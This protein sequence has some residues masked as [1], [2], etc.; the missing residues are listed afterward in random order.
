[1]ILN[2]GFNLIFNDLLIEEVLNEAVPV[3]IEPAEP[4][5]LHD[6]R[7]IASD[8]LDIR[9]EYE[10]SACLVYKDTLTRVAAKVLIFRQTEAGPEVLMRFWRSLVELPGGGFD[11]NKDNY[12]IENTI[13]REVYEEL[14]IEL[15]NIK[16]TK[17]NYCEFADRPWVQK[18]VAK[19]EDRW[20]A[21]YTYVYTA[22]YAGTGS[23][24]L[25]EELGRYKWY[26]VSDILE[27]KDTKKL[28]IYKDA[29]KDSGYANKL[30]EAIDESITLTEERQLGLVSYCVHDISEGG[31]KV[32]TALS[33]L[34]LILEAEK[35][36]TSIDSDKT[37]YVSTSRD[38]TGHLG[39][40]WSC[41]IV[42]DGTKVTNKYK[43]A[44]INHNGQIYFNDM[45]TSKHLSLN[46]IYE[47]TAIGLSKQANL[48]RKMSAK[49]FKRRE[50]ATYDPNN[51]LKFY[52]VDLGGNSFFTII[53][54]KTFDI[55]HDIML[56]YNEMPAVQD[57]KGAAEKYKGR[58]NVEVKKYEVNV[59]GSGRRYNTIA[60]ISSLPSR[61]QDYDF[62][63]TESYKYNV[64]NSGLFIN[65]SSLSRFKNQ[66]LEKYGIDITSNEFFR[67]V[68]GKEYSDEAEERIFPRES[69]V[70]YI[71]VSGCIKLILVSI[72]YYD[73]FEG[74]L[75]DMTKNSDLVYLD[76]EG[77]PTIKNS[78]KNLYY[79]YSDRGVKLDG[80]TYNKVKAP[81]KYFSTDIGFVANIYT[82][83]FKL[84]N[85]AKSLQIPIYFWSSETVS[86]DLIHA[87]STQGFSFITDN[88]RS[89]QYKDY[90]AAKD[91]IA[92]APKM[93]NEK[94]NDGNILT[95]NQVKFF[96][97]SEIRSK[98]FNNKLLVCY[99]ASSRVGKTKI[100]NE[101]QMGINNTYTGTPYGFGYYF[102]E[103]KQSAHVSYSDTN[104]FYL[105]IKNPLII[106]S[107][108]NYIMITDKQGKSRAY[109]PGRLA[110]DPFITTIIKDAGYDG[111][112]VVDEGTYNYIVAFEPNQIKL[113]TNLK[114]TSSDAI[115]E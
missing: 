40:K 23:N 60:Q 108:D 27:K 5:N 54:K 79:Q 33:A 96:E 6:C 100:P 39:R 57:D 32:K 99:S 8:V 56:M 51:P 49:E 114:P 74:A 82:D 47:Y 88:A 97:E 77:N 104:T 11:V 14:N 25:P 15:K 53:S 91:A 83:A 37:R 10:E 103:Y 17:F 22:E 107:R 65:K 72:K 85:Q 7:M 70:E 76:Q 69:D 28:A 66:I 30:D 4:I 73:I 84:I 41:G 112:W 81:Y 80:S 24:D 44:S 3:T 50:K 12:S 26:K 20:K 61:Y 21:Y 63:C 62:I 1:M 89:Q 9:N 34:N 29:I 109:D 52:L 87:C 86:H 42:L 78:S 64:Q 59:A 95:E 43:S 31:A 106:K 2:K 13:K 92:N 19:E 93:S 68:A 90:K 113:T 48:H 111:I 35:I 115:D 71:D 94:D 67:E 75:S 46:G 16:P 98:V 36:K 101:S 110:H 105:N 45:R 58:P 38:L 18:H 55:L 102:T